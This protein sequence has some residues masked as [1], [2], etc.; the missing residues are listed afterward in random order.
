MQENLERSSFR[1]N[2]YII[3]LDGEDKTFYHKKKLVEVEILKQNLDWRKY[4]IWTEKE[5][6]GLKQQNTEVIL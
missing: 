4:V 3:K 5:I 1:L 2:S 6:V